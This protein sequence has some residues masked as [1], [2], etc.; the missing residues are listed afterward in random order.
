MREFSN[1]TVIDVAALMEQVRG[2]MVRMTHAVEYVFG[3]SLLAG[4]A[5]LYAALV[6]TREERVR[7]TTLLRVLGASRRQVIA[8]SLAEFACIGLLAGLV[9]TLAASALAWYVS[10]SILN[11]P[12]RFNLLL[13]LMALVSA[14]LL[15]P[16]AAWV[17]MRGYINQPP[18]KLLQSV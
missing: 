6:A 16:F 2:I 7:E 11:I 14:S 13:A 12:Y 5:V 3:F 1:L 10:T 4:L 8:A 18:R 15:V 9:A 17:G